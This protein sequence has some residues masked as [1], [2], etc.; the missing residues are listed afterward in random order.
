MTLI[1]VHLDGKSPVALGDYC[2]TLDI[3]V[4]SAVAP[5]NCALPGDTPVVFVDGACID[6]GLPTAKG[7]VGIFW[8]VDHVSN[9]SMQLSCSDSNPP[10]NNRAELFAAILA[11]E[12]AIDANLASL[13]IRSDSEYVV[14]SAV[15]FLQSWKSGKELTERKNCDMW[16]KLDKLMPKITLE[17]H[18]RHIGFQD[19]RH[20]KCISFY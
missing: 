16:E 10:T 12:Q 20:C 11:I 19:G 1:M 4:P 2:N 18:G 7:G 3:A 5:Q 8:G 13:I 14:E 15:T 9:T 17:S 6:N